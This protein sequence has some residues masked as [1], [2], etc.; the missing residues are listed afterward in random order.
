MDDNRPF[1]LS[2]YLDWP[3]EMLVKIV[4]S[5]WV[6]KAHKYFESDDLSPSERTEAI[7]ALT[8]SAETDNIQ[9]AATEKMLRAV[10]RAVGMNAEWH[11]AAKLIR[12]YLYGEAS[13]I[14]AAREAATESRRQQAAAK[15][16]RPNVLT[17][18]L[19]EIVKGSPGI[20]TGECWRVLRNQYAG[21]LPIDRVTNT[22]LWYFPEPGSPAISISKATIDDRL[23]RIRDKTALAG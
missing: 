4:F 11:R 8:A 9:S 3:D 10:G 18:I 23:R 20:K 14:K 22:E 1:N 5:L 13:N 17:P 7:I 15:A 21:K 12:G 2:D 6:P 16:D 19:A